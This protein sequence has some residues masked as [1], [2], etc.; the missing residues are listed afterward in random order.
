MRYAIY[1]SPSAKHPL[2][3]AAALWLGRDLYES[4]I[5]PQPHALSA[6]TDE[7]RRYGFH[8]TMKA[9]FRLFGEKSKPELLSAFS[10]FCNSMRAVEIPDLTLS[11]IGPFFALVPGEEAHDVNVLAA[12]VVR[13][14][15][16]FRAPLTDIEI[17]RRRPEKLSQEQRELLDEWGYP[18]VFGEFR[19]HMT[20]TGPVPDAVS[21]DI[22]AELKRRFAPFLGKSLVLDCLSIFTETASGQPFSI[23]K[24]LPLKR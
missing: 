16:P 7:P 11:R 1:F 6:L 8:A 24:Q 22:E 10:A 20:L 2:S 23:L 12:K 3:E 5:L 21:E 15:E 17:E 4:R 13:A 9:P 14:F 19:F 18:Y